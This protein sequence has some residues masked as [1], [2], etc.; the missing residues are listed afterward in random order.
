MAI[1]DATGQ[2][3]ARTDSVGEA[4]F[5]VRRTIQQLA[6]RRLGYATL[7]YVLPPREIDVVDVSI[8]LAPL[9][10]ILSG[11]RVEEKNEPVVTPRHAEFEK[12]LASRQR[13]IFF[14]REEIVRRNTNRL[15]DLFR[16]FPS[17]KIVDSAGVK[18]VAS[19]RSVIPRINSTGRAELRYCLL[20]VVI[21]GQPKEAGF[22]L[23][24]VEP[25]EIYGIEVYD[26]P[27]TV[28]SQYASFG[29]DA[30]CGVILL[31]TR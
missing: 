4:R 18:S 26:G 6:L 31:W 8:R 19:A 9:P 12:R 23:D 21:D 3:L 11:V 2:V 30:N 20:R 29:R 7:E 10:E 15:T 22:P 28:P 27:S 1:V 24:Q 16:G 25:H 13:G 17:L 5:H 14:R